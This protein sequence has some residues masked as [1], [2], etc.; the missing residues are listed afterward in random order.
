MSVLDNA[1]AAIASARRATTTHRYSSAAFE[2]ELMP[3]AALQPVIEPW[4]E[5]AAHAIEPNVFYEPAFALAAAPLLGADVLVGLVWTMETPRRLAGLFPVRIDR[6]R[7]AMPLPVLVSWTH[8]YAPLGTPLVHRDLAEPVIAT[9]LD[10]IAHEPSLPDLLLMHL[11]TEEGPFA[12]ALTSV[13]VRRGCEVK[14]FDREQRAMLDPGDHRMRYFERTMPAKRRRE[15]RRQRRRL[16]QRGTVTVTETAEESELAH[17]F[18][19]FLT[20]EASGWKGRGGTAALHNPG[21]RDFM[22]RAITGLGEQDKTLIYEL[23][24]DNRV[25]ASGIVLKSGNMGWTWKIAFD[26]AFSAYSPGVL[27]MT[28]L[29]KSLLADTALVRV[30][31]CA[32]TAHMMINHLWAERLALADCL[33]SAKADAA[34][35]FALAARLEALRRTALAVAKSVRGQVRHH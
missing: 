10:H 33:V 25:I 4:A 1:C 31:S 24:L 5:L 18:D 9:W 7:Y 8:P 29:T 2:I 3:V 15:L 11:F 35:S 12:A 27:L 20:L 32:T 14:S 21:V 22:Q 23:R 17:S 28:A 6:H 26:E 30:D 19:N 16:E 13:L 34:F